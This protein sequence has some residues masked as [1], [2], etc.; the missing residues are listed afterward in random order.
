MK[1]RKICILTQP[2]WHNYGCLLQ[3]FALQKCLKTMNYDVVTD[4]FPRRFLSPYQ[5]CVDKVKRVVAYYVLG[6]KTV[7]PSP[8]YPT[9]SSW[10]KICANTSKFVRKRIDTVDFFNGSLSPTKEMLDRFDTFIIGSDQVWRESYGRVE[11]YFCDFL[12]QDDKKVFSYAASFGLSH[13]QFNE[14]KTTHLK[15]LVKKFKAVSVREKDAVDLCKENLNIKAEWVL[16]PTLLLS[17]ED[18]ISLF[19]DYETEK[20]EGNFMTYILDYSEE[21]ENLINYIEDSKSLTAFSVM[22][23]EGEEFPAVEKWL[24]G[25]YDAKFVLTDSF[26][27]MVFSIVFEKPFLV[28]LNKQR[29]SSRFLSLLSAL[30]LEDRLIENIDNV[31]SFNEILSKEIDYEIVRKRLSILVNKSKD[32]LIDCLER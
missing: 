8:F 17:K 6:R 26:H 23:N 27:G 10:Q 16:D 13:W 9:E 19:K 5:K 18:Y 28:V 32:F 3:A 25:F 15:E 1:S 22:A 12:K 20:S 4:E 30:G 21:K 31:S 14:E 29:G 2:L 24:K 7:N 11:S